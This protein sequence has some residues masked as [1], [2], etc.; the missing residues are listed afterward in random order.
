MVIRPRRA[1]GRS[2][3]RRSPLNFTETDG[4]HLT[5]KDVELTV[6]MDQVS[7]PFDVPGCSGSVKEPHICFPQPERSGFTA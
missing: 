1:T 7:S 2:G 6:R 3:A 5:R 4:F